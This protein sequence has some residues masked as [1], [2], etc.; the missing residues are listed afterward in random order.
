MGDDKDTPELQP[1]P[2]VPAIG[3]TD[4]GAGSTKSRRSASP[5][6]PAVR[7]AV[8]AAM[9]FGLIAVFVLLPRWQ[10]QRQNGPASG[11]EV[12]EIAPSPEIPTPGG[13]D[14]PTIVDG[15]SPE[16]SPP[17]PPTHTPRSASVRPR[18]T[19]QRKPSVAD[20]QYVDAMSRGLVA[21]ENRQWLAAQDAF[22]MASR[23]R[24]DAPEV[25]DGLARA[26]AG[27]RR[28][29]VADNLRRAH[30]FEENETWRE[31]EKVYSA[32][33][34]LDPESAPALDGRKRTETRA[35]LDEKVEFHLANP[36]RLS[37]ATVFDDAAF[38]LEEALEI[39]PS[40]PR[41]ENQIARLEVLLVHV[42]TPVAVVLESDAQTEIMVY[43]VGR[44]GTFTR[45][46]LNLKPGAYTVVGSRSGYR[47][48]RLYLV[49]TPGTPP[50]PL[51]VR[52]TD[53]L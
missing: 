52:C 42:S 32:V 27:Q 14:L 26:R 1:P 12:Q 38:C 45:R 41:L 50:K 4:P 8:I 40:G 37:T 6:R 13:E 51:V 5:G 31:A 36:G 28:D 43:R 7:A 44:L 34:S 49:V 30:E 18:D 22:A 48:V 21:L 9:V 11:G 53:S 25:A 23:L 47:D 35:I 3:I 16:P 39:R 2:R 24:P 46:E 17:S 20:R 19:P 33:L 15:I 10:E 29:S